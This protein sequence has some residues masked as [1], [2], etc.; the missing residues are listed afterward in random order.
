MEKEKAKMYVENEKGEKK[1][2]FVKFRLTDKDYY[3]LLQLSKYNNMTISEFVRN[4][5][6]V[7][8]RWSYE[9]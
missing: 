5:L 3:R 4:S 6:S 9:K 7:I 2:N 1:T 8:F